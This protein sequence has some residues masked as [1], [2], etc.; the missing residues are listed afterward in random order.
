MFQNIL[1]VGHSN[2]GDVCYDLAVVDPLHKRY[3]EARVAFLTSSRCKGI[4]NNYKG[5]DK[6]ITFDRYGKDKSFFHRLRF[7]LELRKEKFDLAVVL[8]KSMTYKFLGISNAWCLKKG[9]LHPNHPVDLYLKL[10]RVHGIEVQ[11]ASFS[12]NLDDS[13]RIFC[14]NFLKKRSICPKDT[15]I[16]ILPLA[17][18]SLKSWP[19]EKWN[20]LTEILRN[21]YGIKVIN[22]GKMPKNDLGRRISKEISGQI[23]PA[24]ETTL[25][26]ARALLQR[27]HLFIGPDSS[28]LHL[29]SCMGIETIGLYGATSSE[30]FYPYFHRH[31]IV[32][33]EKRLS[34]MPCYPGAG[35]SCQNGETKYDFGPC[36]EAIRVEDVLTAIKERLNLI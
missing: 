12:F 27:C 28:F 6:I 33:L 20:K 8:K 2:I 18:W 10:L 17:A 25:L 26:Q 1:V 34:C 14:E 9:P 29:A 7:I 4:V 13:E 19:I 35:H 16:G 22:L 5:I 32:C 23:I 31:N 21:Q 24:D 3:P 11:T 15:L 30:H 36:M